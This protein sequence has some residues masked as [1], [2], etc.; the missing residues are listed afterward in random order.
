MGCIKFKIN[1]SPTFINW[2]KTSD[3]TLDSYYSEQPG[4]YVHI[5]SVAFHIYD[6]VNLDFNRVHNTSY[7]Y[8]FTPE[9][10]EA[11]YERFENDLED[12]DGNTIICA[13]EY[14][15][16]IDFEGYL[17]YTRTPIYDQGYTAE[18]YTRDGDYTAVK[19]NFYPFNSDDN[20]KYI[21]YYEKDAWETKDEPYYLGDVFYLWD[22]VQVGVDY[23]EEADGPVDA[24]LPDGQ[25]GGYYFGDTFDLYFGFGDIVEFTDDWA[26]G[27]KFKIRGTDHW[28][29]VVDLAKPQGLPS[30]F[31]C[32]K[33]PTDTNGYYQF[34]QY[35][36][37]I[38]GGN[39]NR[40]QWDHTFFMSTYDDFKFL[41]ET[42]MKGK[43]AY[44]LEFGPFSLRA[45]RRELANQL[46]HRARR[47]ARGGHAH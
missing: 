41:V 13:A 3:A 39:G 19:D 11:W 23:D 27:F 22:R 37:R 9:R 43:E 25:D 47:R 36:R 17:N 18:F 26:Y 14:G 5:P 1:P 21:K 42:V 8:S 6:L 4:R 15:K 20:K 16:N 29:Q 45:N 30:N 44:D 28:F 32:V 12:S 35:Y 10:A 31:P 46:P 2:D 34:D 38:Y 40:S 24:W 7:Q 33:D